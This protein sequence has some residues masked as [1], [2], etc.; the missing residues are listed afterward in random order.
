MHVCVHVCECCCC[1]VTPT[2]LK[3]IVAVKLDSEDAFGQRFAALQ[4][5]QLLA[6]PLDAN[7]QRL[8]T[9]NTLRLFGPRLLRARL[10][11]PHNTG[12]NKHTHTHTQTHTHTHSQDVSK[13]TKRQGSARAT[14]SKAKYAIVL[15]W[16][17]VLLSVSYKPDASAAVWILP[18]THLHFLSLLRPLTAASHTAQ[19][20]RRSF[21]PTQAGKD[22]GAESVF[23][24]VFV[25]ACV[26][27]CKSVGLCVFMRVDGR[28]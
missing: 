18:Q 12:P 13:Q 7:T 17:C 28:A 27:V 4:G 22:K 1:R 19:P 20:R 9:S 2:Y 10:Q 16:H 8:C 21:L 15:C 3:D 11:L 25:C 14:A 26:C 6:Q 24:F 5:F 23:V